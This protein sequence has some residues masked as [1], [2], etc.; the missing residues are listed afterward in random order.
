M[1]GGRDGK[2]RLWEAQHSQFFGSDGAAN[3]DGQGGGYVQRGLGG[4]SHGTTAQQQQ[5]L[6]NDSMSGGSGATGATGF[7]AA[8]TAPLGNQR[9]QSSMSAGAGGRTLLKPLM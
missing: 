1:S 8:S 6:A 5:V 3:G 4:A 2:I 9:M 7:T